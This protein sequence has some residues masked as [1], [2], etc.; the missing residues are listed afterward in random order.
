MRNFGQIHPEADEC[1]LS[2]AT[3]GRATRLLTS[4][5][6]QV[7]D[8]LILALDLRGKARRSSVVRSW[9]AFSGTPPEELHYRLGALVSIAESGLAHA[10]KDISNPGILGSIS[11]L[12]ESS[13][14]GGRIEIG[15]IPRPRGV[16]LPEWLKVFPS[17]GF[18]LSAESRDCPKCLRI[19][20]ERGIAA[21]VV[22]KVTD[23]LK[24]KL[25]YRNQEASLFDFSRE[26]ITGI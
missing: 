5:S 14:R 16:S 10:A 20:R 24:I 4:S 11:T 17:Y 7:N 13:K 2:V 25:S 22:G 18:V 3:L 1:S 23:D 19:F 15:R 26:G 6:A 21:E 12:L 9:D 8:E